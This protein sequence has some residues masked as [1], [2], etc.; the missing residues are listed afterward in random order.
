MWSNIQPQLQPQL[1]KPLTLGANVLEISKTPHLLS[2]FEYWIII[3]P[4]TLLIVSGE[5]WPDAARVWRTE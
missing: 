4:G 5:H 1:G 3:D 2:L